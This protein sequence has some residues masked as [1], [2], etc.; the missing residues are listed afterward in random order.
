MFET[1][2][3]SRKKLFSNLDQV[4]ISIL[5][6]VF[7]NHRKSLIQ[8]CERSQLRLHFEWRQKLIKKMPKLVHFGEF[9]KS[10]G[11][12]SNSV[13]RQVSFD[14]TKFGGKCQNSNETFWVIF[15]QCAYEAWGHHSNTNHKLYVQNHFSSLRVWQN[16]WEE[17][18]WSVSSSRQML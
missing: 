6:T 5:C 15:K 8:H 11:L 2:C 14:R 17:D 13:T 12:R 3:I 7:E 4:L 1:L 18:F 10:W 16:G 9:L